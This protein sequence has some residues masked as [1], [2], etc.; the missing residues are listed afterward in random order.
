M[1]QTAAG[2]YSE[3]QVAI[4]LGKDPDSQEVKDD[5]QA[6]SDR[7]AEAVVDSIIGR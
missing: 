1:F 7:I 2:D 6:A 5:V 3:F 4:R